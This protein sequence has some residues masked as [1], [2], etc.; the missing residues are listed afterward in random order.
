MH[1]RDVGRRTGGVKGRMQT[2]GSGVPDAASGPTLDSLTVCGQRL[3]N[4]ADVTVTDEAPA[5]IRT[6]VDWIR[7][8]IIRP[9][10]ALGRPGAVCPFVIPALNLRCLW[11]A[12][13]EDARTAEQV[14]EVVGE[15]LA[16]YDR[17]QPQVGAHT[18]LRTFIAILPAL[19][20]PD[21]GV[22]IETVHSR[23]KAAVVDRGLMLGEF[24]P[25]SLSPGVHNPRFY[26]LR[27]PLPLFVLRRMVP[28]DLVFL[29]KASDPPDRRAHYLRAYVTA[30]GHELSPERAAEAHGALA[31][32]ESELRVSMGLGTSRASAAAAAA[33]DPRHRS[34]HD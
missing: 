5:P 25:E 27:S 22:L 34:A 19:T 24:Y 2:Q 4:A 6:I 11:L 17:H 33:A 13:V 29:N 21:R 15:C 8:H 30:L 14:S 31:T 23:M 16:L 26:P 32:T 28:G 7:G 3:W 20:A 10:T 9:N 18:G 12:V 1:P